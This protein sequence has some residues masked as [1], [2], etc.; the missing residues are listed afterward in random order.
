MA[1]GKLLKRTATLAFTEARVEDEAGNLCAHATGTF[2]LVR[3]VATGAR[4][5]SPFSGS[6]SD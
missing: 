3:G 4:E 1:Y 5:I 2:K 6:G